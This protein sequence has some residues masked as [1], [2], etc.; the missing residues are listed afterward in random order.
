MKSSFVPGED[1]T[2]RLILILAGDGAIALEVECLNARL[3][4]VSKPYAAPSGHAPDHGD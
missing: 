2:G 3:R 1:G 4:D